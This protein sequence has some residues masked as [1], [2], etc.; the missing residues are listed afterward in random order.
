MYLSEECGSLRVNH[1]TN[2]KRNEQGLATLQN[3]CSGCIFNHQLPTLKLKPKRSQNAY[4]P[5]QALV[6]HCKR[7]L[8]RCLCG[9]PLWADYFVINGT[10]IRTNY[11]LDIFLDI[12]LFC[13]IS[14]CEHL[15]YFLNHFSSF[16]S[17]F[18][19]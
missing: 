14:N 4:L 13:R 16:I 18:F 3:E 9:L 7:K 10:E 2:M 15:T 12:Y 8:W 6:I 19:Q 11:I 1:S 5:L 17:Y